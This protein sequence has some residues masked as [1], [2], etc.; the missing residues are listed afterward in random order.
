MGIARRSQ[1]CLRAGAS[2]ASAC[3]LVYQAGAV[4]E[5]EASAWLGYHGSVNGHYFDEYE[6]DCGAKP[7]SRACRNLSAQW[8]TN[9]RQNTELLFQYLASYGASEVLE[10][11]FWNREPDRAWQVNNNCAQVKPWK[12]AASEAV[13]YN[14]VQTLVNDKGP[15]VARASN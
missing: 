9:C 5:A 1:Q 3:T 7:K 11:D 6:S 2:C 8:A 13:A 15:K 4:R 12:M 10:K 14:I